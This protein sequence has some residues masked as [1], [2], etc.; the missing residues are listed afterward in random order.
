MPPSA[1]VL[2]GLR[3]AKGGRRADLPCFL[4]YRDRGGAIHEIPIRFEEMVD[5]LNFLNETRQT[6]PFTLRHDS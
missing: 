6:L 3:I 2:Q 5:L 1:V 4:S